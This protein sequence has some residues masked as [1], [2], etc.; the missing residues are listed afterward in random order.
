MKTGVYDNTTEDVKRQG[1]VPYNYDYLVFIIYTRNFESTSLTC[2]KSIF[3]SFQIEQIAATLDIS[4]DKNTAL[5]IC[6][7]KI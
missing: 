1:S 6:I 5:V 3:D 7:G 4:A 2:A